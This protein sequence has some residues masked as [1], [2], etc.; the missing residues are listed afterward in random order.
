MSSF[1]QGDVTKLHQFQDSRGVL[2]QAEMKVIGSDSS[3]C[4]AL[5]VHSLDSIIYGFTRIGFS[6]WIY[7][8]RMPV[9]SEA[10]VRDLLT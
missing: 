6:S 7:F 1:N 8:P 3:G 10:S 5:N 2:H 4:L 9:E